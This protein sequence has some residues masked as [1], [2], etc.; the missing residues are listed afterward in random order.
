MW[1][2]SVQNTKTD[3]ALMTLALYKQ[4]NPHND[5]E[6]CWFPIASFTGPNIIWEWSLSVN[7]KV[8]VG[9]S[10]DCWLFWGSAHWALC[11]DRKRL[12]TSRGN[13][14]SACLRLL[15][16]FS[17]YRV[18][19]FDPGPLTPLTWIVWV[20]STWPMLNRPLTLEHSYSVLETWSPL[21]VLLFQFPVCK[22]W[23]SS[24]DGCL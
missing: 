5:S 16:S 19:G 9:C 12:V 7:F 21:V 17:T 13:I 8:R 23:F 15:E 22:Y 4:T 10:P 14:F 6:R 1:W 11:V 3:R 24:I 18:I 20:F 2:D